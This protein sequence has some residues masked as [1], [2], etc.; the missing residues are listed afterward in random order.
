MRECAVK[1]SNTERL[2]IKEYIKKGVY[3]KECVTDRNEKVK[4]KE[5]NKKWYNKYRRA[6]D[7][8]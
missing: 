5:Q 1:R 3:E 6:S 2:V 4:K 8:L 7:P